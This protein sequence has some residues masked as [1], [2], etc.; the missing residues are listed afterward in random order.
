MA[1]LVTGLPV[2]LSLCGLTYWAG[3]FD[4]SR[5]LLFL[6][7]AGVL[8]SGFYFVAILIK[9]LFQNTYYYFD[10]YV[11]RLIL[12]I[13]MMY[14]LLAGMYQVL[15]EQHSALVDGLARRDAIIAALIYAA[16]VFFL[17]EPA[18]WRSAI[19]HHVRKGDIDP[20]LG[21]SLL[22]APGHDTPWENWLQRQLYQKKWAHVILGLGGGL[23]TFISSGAGGATSLNILCFAGGL[24]ALWAA[25]FFSATLT[26]FVVYFRRYER[27]VGHAIIV[28]V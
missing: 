13:T 26:W 28:R 2:T 19:P 9:R 11:Y 15:A 22:L 12:G 20:D 16:Y 7:F 8:G 18:R 27:H 5:I 17:S 23:A 21:V 25:I 10:I 14:A 3:A 6:F 1:V 24:G 4:S